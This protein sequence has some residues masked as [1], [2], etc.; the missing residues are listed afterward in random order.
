MKSPT[1]RKTPGPVRGTRYRAK[2]GPVQGVAYPK[3]PDPIAHLALML[4]NGADIRFIQAMLGHAALSSTE[5]YTH[6][7]I[8]KL[9]QIHA[10]THPA[11]LRRS[12]AKGAGVDQ[13]QAHEELLRAIL[14]DDDGDIGNV[15]GEE[16]GGESHS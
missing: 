5:R 15:S 3:K 2:P 14:D 16:S 4:D 8:G 6:V 12:S 10:A 1:S 9:Q 11:K 7:A 13:K